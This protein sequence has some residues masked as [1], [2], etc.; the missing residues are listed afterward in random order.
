MRVLTLI[1]SLAVGGA[2]QSLLTVTPHLVKRGIDVHVAYLVERDGI[3][4]EIAEAGATVHSLAGPAGRI[5]AVRRARAL[6]A[7]LQPDLTHTTLFEADVVGRIAARLAGAPV[8]SSFVTESYGPEHYGNPEYRRWK[9]RAAHLAD[10][11]TARLATRFHAVSEA[12]ARVMAER[13]RLDP[14]TIT[15]IPRGRDPERLGERTEQRRREARA[16][17][18]VGHEEPLVLAAGRHFH[19]K[20]LDVVAA[21]MPFV[22]AAYPKARLVIAGREGPSTAELRQRIVEG[23]VEDAVDL[24]GYRSDVPDLMT[25]ADVFV[26]PS[27]AE[28]SPGVLLEAMALE[29]PVVATDISAVREIAGPTPTMILTPPDHPEP[30]ANAIVGVL[31]D[32]GAASEL[33]ASARRRFF[34]TYTVER[35][36][37]RTIA[38]YEDAVGSVGA[39]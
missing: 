38:L 18:G 22:R 21:A 20:G 27:R 8:I 14:A 24:I 36:A 1:D 30:M 7:S 15:V 35:V 12:T 16:M 3:G 2:E 9:V 17:L 26:L 4:P 25:A 5:A 39:A 13:L 6:I 10:A 31:G 34:D 37:E 28:G 11:A 32:P 19:F 29:V 23:G 33:A